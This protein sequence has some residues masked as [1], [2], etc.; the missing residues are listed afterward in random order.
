VEI[1]VHKVPRRVEIGGN[2]WKFGTKLVKKPFY[3]GRDLGVFILR[4]L[5]TLSPKMLE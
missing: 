2:W 1:L 3:L 5:G 4:Q